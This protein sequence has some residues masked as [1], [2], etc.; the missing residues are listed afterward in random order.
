MANKHTAKQGKKGL[1]HAVTF[2]TFHS[3][4]FSSVEPQIS[5]AM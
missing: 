5:E 3:F 2:E 1:E 4:P